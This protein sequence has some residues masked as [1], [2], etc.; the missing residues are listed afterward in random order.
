MGE[1]EAVFGEPLIGRTSIIHHSTFVQ[2]VEEE[3]I[4]MGISYIHVI[5]AEAF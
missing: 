3:L 5:V 1:L 4:L 2:L